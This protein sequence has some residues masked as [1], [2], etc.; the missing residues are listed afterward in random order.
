MHDLRLSARRL[1]DGSAIG[2]VHAVQAQTLRRVPFVRP[3][4]MRVQA[5]AKRVFGPLGEQHAGTQHLIGVPAGAEID[6]INDPDPRS[7]RYAAVFVEL[8]SELLRQFRQLHGAQLAS[9]PSPTQPDV[10]LPADAVLELSWQPLLAAWQTQAPDAVL[11]HHLHGVLLALLLAGR[12]QLLFQPAAAPL[13][14]QV[15]LLL[16]LDPAH[17]WSGDEVAQRLNRSAAT[18][19]RQLAAEG[20]GFRELLDEVRLG[21]GL[22]LLQMG[23]RP[24]N[25]VAALCGYESASKFAA[26]FRERFGLTPSALRDSQRAA[27]GH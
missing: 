9:L 13:A 19:R 20:S 3:T 8:G 5:G 15:R 16:Q 17:G 23:E 24:I 10:L 26:R 4:L 21:Y 7:G 14:E 22:G 1:A 25:E 27:A 11:S 18:L 6:L 2:A 12:G